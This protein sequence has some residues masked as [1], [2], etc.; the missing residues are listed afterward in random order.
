MGKNGR[1]MTA[2][3]ETI[4]QMAIVDGRLDRRYHNTLKEL[5]KDPD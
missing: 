5:A 3:E 4:R 2:D 1:L